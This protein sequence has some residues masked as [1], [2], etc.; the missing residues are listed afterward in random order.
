MLQVRPMTAT[1]VARVLHGLNSS[2]YPADQWSKC[3]FWGQYIQVGDSRGQGI[4]VGGL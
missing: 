2:S 1:A 4:Q 3:G